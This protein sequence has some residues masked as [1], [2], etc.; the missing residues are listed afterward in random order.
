MRWLGADRSVVARKALQ[1]GWSEGIGSDNH[2]FETTGDRM[3]S[4]A[5]RD[6]P[7]KIDKRQVYKAYKAVKSNQGAAGVDG[8]FAEAATAY[9]QSLRFLAN[10]PEYSA[11]YA[12]ALSAYAIL[13]RDTARMEIA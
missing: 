7:F 8:R 6:K 10:N 2:T 12:A 4:G 5:V 13:Y 9:E 11:Q 3:T 1:W